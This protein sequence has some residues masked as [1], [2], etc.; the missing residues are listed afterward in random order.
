VNDSLRAASCDLRSKLTAYGL[1]SCAWGHLKTTGR[2]TAR[3]KPEIA[4][5]EIDRLVT[6]G[7]RFTTV[8]ADDGYGLSAP[9]RQGL[10]ARGLAWA[11]GIPKL[12]RQTSQPQTPIVR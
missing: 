8:L 7:V 6:A 10:S 3:T 2:P 12:V 11:V 4:L 5:G 9:F 1:G